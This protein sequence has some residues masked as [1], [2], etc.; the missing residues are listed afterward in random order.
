MIP[1][2][3]KIDSHEITDDERNK[4]NKMNFDQYMGSMT[5]V[6][7]NRNIL[8]QNLMSQNNANV[9]QSKSPFKS[10]ENLG[11]AGS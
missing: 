9:K 2:L 10:N 1:Q 6:P 4:A 3:T 11:G 8:Q 5:K 7:S